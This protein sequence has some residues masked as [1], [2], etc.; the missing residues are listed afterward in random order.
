[1]AIDRLTPGTV[2]EFYHQLSD[3]G[4][5]AFL[6]LLGSGISAEAMYFM[7][8][9]MDLVENEKFCDMFEK[10]CQPLYALLLN[11]AVRAAREHPNWTDEDLKREVGKGIREHHDLMYR[12]LMELGKAKHKK[13]RDRKSDPEKVKRNVEICDLRNQ[14]KKKWSHGRLAKKFKTSPPN[15]RLILADEAHWRREAARLSSN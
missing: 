1:M 11:R 10:E 6:Q 12:E 8:G 9:C 13:E 7:L 2:I 14:D 5:R 4:K 15:I 3:G